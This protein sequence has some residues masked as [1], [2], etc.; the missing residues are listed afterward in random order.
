MTRTKGTVDRI[1]V[2]IARFEQSLEALR[3]IPKDSHG[4]A[5]N[6]I[7]HEL[8]PLL[9]RLRTLREEATGE[10]DRAE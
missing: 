2:A 5:L 6:G 8:I 7:E 10:G 4:V 1:D 3:Q 9:E